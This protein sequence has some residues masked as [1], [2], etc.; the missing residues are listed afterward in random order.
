MRRV[1]IVVAVC[2]ALAS[3]T[4]EEAKSKP[5]SPPPAAAPAAATTATTGPRRVPVEANKEGYTPDQIPG[6][7]GEKLVL[8]FTRTVDSSCLA[9]LR[10]PDGKT[11]DLPMNKPVEVPVTVPDSGQLAFACG[12]DMFHGAIVAQPKG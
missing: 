8:V 6:A 4:K 5:A 12:M 9:Q 10:T 2:L 7:P 3:C 11:V 1:R